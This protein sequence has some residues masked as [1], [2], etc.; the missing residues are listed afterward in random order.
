MDI[1]KYRTF[2][3]A[4]RCRSFL[5]AANAL[6]LPTPT[7]TKHISAL[8]R[9]MG[10]S[11]FERLPHG[12]RLTEEG[13]RRLPLA[14]AMLEAY[15]ELCA[16]N[17]D[18]QLRIDSI[19]CQQRV[20]LPELLAG[21]EAAHPEITV[22]ITERHGLRLVQE[23]LDSQCE[24]GFCG[25]RYIDE[26]ML[27]YIE[28]FQTQICAILPL[29]HPLAGQ[30]SLSLS[31]LKDSP[32]VLLSQ[33]SGMYLFYTDCCLRCGFRPDVR[34]TF[35]REDSLLSY[36]KNGMGVS[37]LDRKAIRFY[38]LDGVRAVP[39]REDFHSGCALVRKRQRRL[40]PPAE[41]FW[42]YVNEAVKAGILDKD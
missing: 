2:V 27:E 5:E 37:L 21:F 32:F 18:K 13:R 39:L 8:E 15:D 12:A 30:E 20:G 19:P 16:M 23:L 25:T 29:E 40:S 42:N 7:V 3:Q 10:V 38:D 34:A 22:T 9:E 1:E 41:A 24:L 6:Y 11:L 17:A 4:A 26:Q 31:Q 14:E 33:E 35:S 36:V 28:L